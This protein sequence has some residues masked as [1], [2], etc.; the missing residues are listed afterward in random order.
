MYPL[1]ILECSMERHIPR[2]PA[3]EIVSHTFGGEAATR[4]GDL[5]PVSS[6]LHFAYGGTAKS[7]YR[8]LENFFLCILVCTSE[9]APYPGLFTT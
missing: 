8:P 4:A 3:R 2:S 7:A 5:T 6:M 9:G 1:D